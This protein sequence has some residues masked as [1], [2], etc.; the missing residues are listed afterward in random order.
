MSRGALAEALRSEEVLR[1]APPSPASPQV[2]G[3][4]LERYGDGDRPLKSPEELD[5][6][7]QRLAAVGFAW[8]KV[9]AADR[10]DIVWVLWRGDDP[11]AEHAAFLEN[12]LRW[13]EAPWRRV[14]ARRLASSWAAAFDDQRRSIGQVGSWLQARATRLG[15]PWSALAETFDVFAPDQGPANLARAFLLRDATAAAFWTRLRLPPRAASGGF[16]LASLGALAAATRPRLMEEPAL[17]VRLMDFAL[18]VGAFR[19]GTVSSDFAAAIRVLLAETLL[20]PWRCDPPPPMVKE[21]VVGFLLRHYEDPRVKREAWGGVAPAAVKILRDWLNREAITI[22]FRLAARAKEAQKI[23]WRRREK[24]WLAAIDRLDDA[25]LILGSQSEALIKS[26]EGRFGRLVGCGAE[27]CALMLK[28]RGVTIVESSHAE[29]ERIWLPGNEQA[30]PRYYGPTRSYSAAALTTG[31]DF[32]SS[33]ATHDGGGA[34]KHL[35]DFVARHT[36][37]ALDKAAASTVTT[38]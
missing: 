2:A 20:L 5:A 28:L 18:V 12:F 11:P 19:P 6:L 32:S 23:D 37:V 31:A 4:L 26:G 27:H 38:R 35:C 36:G 8:D 22:F 7:L 29:N 13:V 9:S 21:K 17:A 16:A 3:L 14:Q 30:P 1:F 25:W 10:A 24:F 33:Y 15:D 34:Q